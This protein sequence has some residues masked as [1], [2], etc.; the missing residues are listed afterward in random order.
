M[1]VLHRYESPVA[2]EGDPDLVGPDEWN[3]DHVGGVL[4]GADYWR[5]D[6]ECW[7]GTS[8]PG[9]WGNGAIT[10]FFSGGTIGNG[11]AT[12]DHPGTITLGTGTSSSGRS[13]LASPSNQWVIGGGLLRFG[14]VFQM[15]SAASNAL[16]NGTDRYTLQVGLSNSSTGGP[17]VAIGFR[18]SDNLSSGNWEAISLRT[19]GG[20]ADSAVDTGVAHAMATW[21]KLEFEINAAGTEILYYING[22]LE[23]TETTN[24]E[25]TAAMALH[26]MGIYKA[27]GS[28]NRFVDLDAFWFEQVLTTPR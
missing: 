5:I 28:G 13:S 25:A 27:L 23:H 9:G 14:C 20:G 7:N 15:R 16:S 17:T 2:D 8:I 18:Y 10:N 3:D 12:A 26:P 19:S 6:D 21:F 1:G 4:S 24:I 11:V 22:T